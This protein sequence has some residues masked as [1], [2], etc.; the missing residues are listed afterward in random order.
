M[1]VRLLAVEVAVEEPD[2]SVGVD[3]A[4]VPGELLELAEL[5]PGAVVVRV[6]PAVDPEVPAVVIVL[7]VEEETGVVSVGVVPPVVLVVL[8]VDT[9]VEP[10]L[11]DPCVVLGEAVELPAVDVLGTV[12]VVVPIE[13][14]GAV[15]TIVAELLPEVAVE[16]EGEVAAVVL[17]GELLVL[18]PV[19][20]V[21]VAGELLVT[22]LDEVAL[23]EGVLLQKGVVH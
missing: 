2:V 5:E 1:A 9:G 3:P 4:V 7:G 21:L 22:P 13:L 19:A 17:P 20:A 10:L 18:P 23:V 6:D 11:V 12:A 16:D 8:R 14:A 15:V